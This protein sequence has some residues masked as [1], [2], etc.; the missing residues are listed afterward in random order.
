MRQGHDM[1]G[2]ARLA[3]V[4]SA[5]LLMFSSRLSAVDGVVI[6]ATTNQPQPDVAVNLVQPGKSGMQTIGSTKSDVAGR[7]RIEKTVLGPQLIQAVYK[8]V[9]YNKMVMPGAPASNLE[10]SV[11]ESTNKRGTAQV[12]QHMILLQP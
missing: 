5:F 6:N 4:A 12:T 11:Y 7:F 2:A 8:G 1:S 9:T 3:P 10:V